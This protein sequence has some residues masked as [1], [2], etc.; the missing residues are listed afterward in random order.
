ML[1]KEEHED[2][3]ATIQHMG[4]PKRA[5]TTLFGNYTHDPVVQLTV[6]AVEDYRKQEIEKIKRNRNK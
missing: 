4:V 5:K 1:N 3:I 2:V 6:E